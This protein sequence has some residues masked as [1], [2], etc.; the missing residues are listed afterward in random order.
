MLKLD[1]FNRRIVWACVEAQSGL[2][3][4]N[5]TPTIKRQLG[6]MKLAALRVRFSRA[7]QSGASTSLAKIASFQ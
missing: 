6:P 5:L 1:Y 7:L 3:S 4:L 2:H